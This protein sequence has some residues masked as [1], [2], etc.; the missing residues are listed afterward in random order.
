MLVV[1]R[2]DLWRKGTQIFTG[3]EEF[4]L[5]KV[6]RF[7]TIERFSCTRLSLMLWDDL[8][9]G[10]PVGKETFSGKSGLETEAQ[11][12][13]QR[14]HRG[15]ISDGGYGWGEKSFMIQPPFH[16]NY[17]WRVLTAMWEPSMRVP[18]AC[19]GNWNSNSVT[20]AEDKRSADCVGPVVNSSLSR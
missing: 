20:S 4:L 7:W 8:I 15:A 3:A 10:L 9:W 1:F 5:G 6:L 11:K 2:A 18:M 14:D 12:K 16:W 17:N 13:S 19:V